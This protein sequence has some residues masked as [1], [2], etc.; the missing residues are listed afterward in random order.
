MEVWTDRERWA[1]TSSCVLEGG[2]A[3]LMME[4]GA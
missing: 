2:L 3:G 4:C 1:D